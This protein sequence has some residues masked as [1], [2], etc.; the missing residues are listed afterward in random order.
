MRIRELGADPLEDGN[1]IFFLRGQAPGS[2]HL[3]LVV[4]ERSNDCNSPGSFRQRQERAFVAKQHNGTF[5]RG[6]GYLTM[7]CNHLGMRLLRRIGVRVLEESEMIL[8]G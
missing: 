7:L 3:A 6:S 8:R 5:R 4:A 1:S 2:I